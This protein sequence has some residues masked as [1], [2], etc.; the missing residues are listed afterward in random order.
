LGSIARCMGDAAASMVSARAGIAALRAAPAAL[1]SI[2]ASAARGGSGCS[3]A[4]VM[5]LILRALDH[6]PPD[7]GT[8]AKR[9][10]SRPL[11]IRSTGDRKEAGSRLIGSGRA[12]GAAPSRSDDVVQL[13]A[14]RSRWPAG[15]HETHA[16]ASGA[17]RVA[18]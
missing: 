5:F 8:A 12:S 16:R 1:G 18:P 9:L 14:L 13:P 11:A 2:V 6:D 17:D 3:S 10:A 7:D 15:L 4:P